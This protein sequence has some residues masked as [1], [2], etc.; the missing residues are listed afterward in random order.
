MKNMKLRLLLQG[1]VFTIIV[2]LE[3]FRDYRA[4]IDNNLLHII[5][6]SI[7]VI[8]SVVGLVLTINFYLKINK[9]PVKYL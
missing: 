2:L 6:N 1:L 4:V 3:V 7:G 8:C 5:I 9:K